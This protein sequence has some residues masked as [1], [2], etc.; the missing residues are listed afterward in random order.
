MLAAL[1]PQIINAL[2]PNGQLPKAGEG[3]DPADV[4]GGLLK[5][6]GG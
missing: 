1:L 5:G 2:T 4:I 6:L 3:G